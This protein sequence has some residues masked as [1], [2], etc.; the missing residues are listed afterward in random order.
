[1]QY[2]RARTW[3]IG[4]FTLN[5]TAINIYYMMMLYIAYFASGVLGLGVALVSGLIATMAVAEGAVDPFIG[6]LIDRRR[7]RFGKFR[8]F[9]VMGNGIMALSLLLMYLSQ[10][11][12]ALF[13]IAYG[14][15]IIGYS[16]QFC[17]TRGA[18]SVLTN[19]PKQRPLISAFDMVFN[20]MLYVGV[21]FA[22]S[23]LLVPRYGGF[24]LPMFRQFF[25]FTAGASAVCTVLAIVGIWGKDREAY[26]ISTKVEVK[27]RHCID[28]LRENRNIRM[29]MVAS[30]TDKLFSNIT[31]NAVV[32]VMIYGIIAG[33]FAL[34]GQMNMFVFAPSMVISLLCVAY[35]RKK[36]Q[37]EALLFSTWGGILFTALILLLFVLGNPMTLSFTEWGIFTVLFMGFLALRGGFMSINNSIIMPMVADCIDHE[38][39]RSRRYAPGMIGA[40]FSAAD[41]L[42]TSLN[43]LVIGGLLIFIGY[44]D[45]F[46]TV[47]T[48]YSRGIFWVAM[49]C[50]CGLPILGWIINLLCLKRYSLDRDRMADVQRGL[51]N[52]NQ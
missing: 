6:W 48:P 40:L 14:V 34:S 2:H 19:D 22:V 37:K 49:I 33:N 12:V 39:A 26:Y 43:T 16:F 10:G 11:A 4:F 1:M 38:T 52:N 27:L 17:V 47:D 21:T 20:V 42:V 45:S 18:Q 30:S 50:F 41:K 13:V 35:A 7:S 5:N 46:P 28:I 32:T 29:L 9:M 8:P 3:Q 51:H 24:T 23:N 44:R 25:L 36:G 31:Q 15:F